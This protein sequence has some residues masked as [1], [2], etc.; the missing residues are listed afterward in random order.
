MNNISNALTPDMRIDR[1]IKHSRYI[2]STRDGYEYNLCK[3]HRDDLY[4]VGMLKN[5][6]HT[7]NHKECDIC[8]MEK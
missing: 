6:I 3:K 7:Y 5:S 4:F 1:H 2:V 8:Q